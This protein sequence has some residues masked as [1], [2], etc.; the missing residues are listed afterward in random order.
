[1]ISADGNDHN[2]GI[3]GHHQLGR[4]HDPKTHISTAAHRFGNIPSEVAIMVIHFAEKCRRFVQATPQLSFLFEQHDLVAALDC[5]LGSH[6][7]RR[8]TADDDDLLPLVR[9]LNRIVIKLSPQLGVNRTADPSSN[10]RTR[11]TLNAT[12]ARA[13]ELGFSAVRLVH[14]VHIRK[15]AAGH[16]HNVGL[17]FCENLF[18]GGDIRDVPDTRYGYIELIVNNGSSR[19]VQA[20]ILR[21]PGHHVLH[22]HW[23]ENPATRQVGVIDIGRS[24]LEKRDN[25]FELDTPIHVFVLADS[26]VNRHIVADRLP[27]LSNKLQRESHPILGRTAVSI[28]PVIGRRRKKGAD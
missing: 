21:I 11:C 9:L 22:V 12:K 14:E 1:M 6:H 16:G 18:G 25:V 28:C 13:D 19:N 23:I 4:R 17:A 27:N 3:L 15:N 5:C 26:E 2:I 10:S 7:S 20:T 24:S 8:S